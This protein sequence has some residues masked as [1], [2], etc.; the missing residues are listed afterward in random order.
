MAKRR[1]HETTEMLADPGQSAALAEGTHG[2]PFAYLGLH[3]L[4]DG[5]RVVRVFRPGA[6]S[7]E[8]KSRGASAAAASSRSVG[9]G[10]AWR[11]AAISARFTATILSST[12]VIAQ[13][14]QCL[15]WRR[16]VKTMGMLRSL[17]AATTSS[18]R[19]EP[20]G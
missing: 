12:L 20:P 4:A 16:P 1:P 18:S 3:S 2:N 7:A 19:R 10:I 17:Q 8:K 9:S 13:A 11:A 15:K 5:R 6:E 14:D